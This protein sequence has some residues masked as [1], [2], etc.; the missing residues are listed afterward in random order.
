M[1]MADSGAQIRPILPCRFENGSEK[2]DWISDL[3]REDAINHIV[4]YVIYCSSL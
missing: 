2:Y 1:R 3:H 4:L